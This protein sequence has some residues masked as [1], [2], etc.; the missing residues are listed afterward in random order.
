VQY[1]T[2]KKKYLRDKDRFSKWS[3]QDIEKNLDELIAIKNRVKERKFVKPVTPQEIKW[4]R[5][6]REDERYSYYVKNYDLA[7][8]DYILEHIE[9]NETL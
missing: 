2:E 1:V 6:F 7:R 8:M 5:K 3:Y 4:L 9:D